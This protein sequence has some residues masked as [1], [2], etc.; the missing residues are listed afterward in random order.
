MK[1]NEENAV[2]K[3]FKNVT[4]LVPIFSDAVYENATSMSALDRNV[5]E[6]K[7]KM[8]RSERENKRMPPEDFHAMR[9]R[10]KMY[11]GLISILNYAKNESVKRPVNRATMMTLFA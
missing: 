1:E 11:R 4:Q 2:V 9:R 7:L 10:T 8:E 6:A 3:N 5:C